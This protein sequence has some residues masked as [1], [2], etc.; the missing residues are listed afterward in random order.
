MLGAWDGGGQLLGQAGKLELNSL[1]PEG[2]RH[3]VWLRDG[4]SPEGRLTSHMSSGQTELREA[5]LGGMKE[6]SV[7]GAWGAGK[8]CKE[9]SGE[10]A[11]RGGSCV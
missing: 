7:R 10:R 6:H 9:P 2:S 4:A 5:D 3:G 11:R 8:P 1:V